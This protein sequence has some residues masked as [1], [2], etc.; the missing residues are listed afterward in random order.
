MNA[1]SPNWFGRN[2]KWAVPVG[3][4]TLA[5]LFLGAIAAFVYFLFGVMKN[6]EPYQHAVGV[7]QSHPALV[8]ALGSPV[9]AGFM[10]SGS[11][12]V[13]DEEGNA[14]LSFPV[15]GPRGEATVH[16]A[17]R[18]VHGVWIYDLIEADLGAPG[19]IDLRDA[20]PRSAPVP[21]PP[22]P[23]AP[24]QPPAPPTP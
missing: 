12:E 7:A 22:E 4:L 3:C 19:R 8:Q 5:L 10:L 1:D 13:A 18:K 24:P 6:A 20:A 2:W 23:P 11:I 17:A 15:E 16:V 9:R 14:D 21:A